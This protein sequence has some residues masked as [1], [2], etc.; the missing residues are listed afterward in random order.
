MQLL[1][2]K[3]WVCSFS[4]DSW[5]IMF[6]KIGM[7]FKL[8]VGL[9]ILWSRWLTKREHVFSIWFSFFT[10]TPSSWL[11]LSSMINTKPFVMGTKKPRPWRKST[12]NMLPF[13][14]CGIHLQL[15]TKAPFMNSTIGSA[16]GIFVCNNGEV[17]CWM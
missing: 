8:F 5:Q 2:R 15:P 14:L 7:L 4:R 9:E 16:F 1:R 12:F 6:K 17:S 10:N 13:Y 3:G 11:H